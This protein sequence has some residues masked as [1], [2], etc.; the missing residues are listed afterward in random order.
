MHRSFC[1]TVAKN[2][3]QC[4]GAKEREH[5]KYCVLCHTYKPSACPTTDEWP[6]DVHRYIY[7]SSIYD[8][9]WRLLLPVVCG[10]IACLHA[11]FVRT[12]RE[13]RLGSK[14]LH[15]V[16]PDFGVTNRRRLKAERTKGFLKLLPVHHLYL[17][18]TWTLWVCFS[19]K[20]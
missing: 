10:V 6:T 19:F 1:P 8:C 13:A 20:K 3:F 18:F 2:C 12:M 17:Y 5:C 15:T 9:E 7:E 11:S 4:D 16:N 14:F